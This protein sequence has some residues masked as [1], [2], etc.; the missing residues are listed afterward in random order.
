MSPRKNTKEGDTPWEETCYSLVVNGRCNGKRGRVPGAVLGGRGLPKLE[1]LSVRL[2]YLQLL[3][4][5]GCC[6]DRETAL[7]ATERGGLG[8]S[9]QPLLGQPSQASSW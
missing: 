2:W 9:S 5:P 4:R 3:Q 1:Q 6:R 7:G 8:R